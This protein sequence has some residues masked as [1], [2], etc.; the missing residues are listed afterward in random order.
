MGINDF[1]AGR[2]ALG[3]FWIGYH[4][5]KTGGVCVSSHLAQKK[6]SLLGPTQ[7]TRLFL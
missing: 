1:C 3:R 4:N 7:R 6:I 2:N 5:L